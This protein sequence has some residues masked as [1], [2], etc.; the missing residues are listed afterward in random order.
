MKT[1]YIDEERNYEPIV[2]AY[3]YNPVGKGRIK[4]EFIIDT[5][6]GGGVLIPLDKYLKLELNLF[7]EPKV[8]GRTA[9]GGSVELRTSRVFVEIG[10]TKILCSAYTTLGVRRSLLGR[11]VL[12]KLGL[13]YNP[14]KILEIGLTDNI[15]W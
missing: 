11:E 13:I 4:E 3:L 5:G 2:E 8:I 12:K 14:P 9:I 15:K 10:N 6:F 1:Y 7:E